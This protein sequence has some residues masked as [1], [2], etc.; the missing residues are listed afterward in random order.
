MQRK[1]MTYSIYEIA[2][3]FARTIAQENPNQEIVYE[4]EQEL[5]FRTTG[6]ANFLTTIVNRFIKS[7]YH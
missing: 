1:Y 2:D 5:S 7:R 6:Y 3:L 4:I